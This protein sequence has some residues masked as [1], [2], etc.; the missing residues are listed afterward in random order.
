[1]TSRELLWQFLQEE[2]E[3]FARGEIH[4]APCTH[5]DQAHYE[6]GRPCTRMTM[7]ACAAFGDWLLAKGHTT[8]ERLAQVRV[9]L[10]LGGYAP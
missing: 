1:M 6:P 7:E 8:P 9:K 4:E 10:E 2:P 3:W 5:T